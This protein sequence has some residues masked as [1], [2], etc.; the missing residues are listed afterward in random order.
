M[1]RCYLYWFMASGERL[2]KI[3][4]CGFR[5]SR[6][7]YYA[8]LP[9][10]EIQHT[11]Y[12]PPLLATLEKWRN[13]AP[14]GF[15]FTLKAWQ[16]IT[17]QPSSPTYRR[18]KRELSD[19]ERRQA[20]SFRPSGIVEE[21]WETTYEC[22]KALDAKAVLFQC[23]ASFGPT[24]DNLKNMLGFFGRAKRE[25]LKF[26]WEP[27]GGWPPDLIGD[28]CRDLDLWHVVDPFSLRTVTPGRCYFRLHGRGGWRYSYEDEEM[29]E[30]Y[31]MLP[32]G[33]ESYV[34]FNNI[35]MRR[36]AL[37]FKEIASREK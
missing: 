23:P 35:E 13:E 2:V 7:S 25:G 6:E 15:E 10:V 21:A 18:L 14:A 33:A 11:F 36:D 4:C 32:E 17:H 20:G 22:A 1:R 30:L 37:R 26:C 28:L 16:L 24:N 29:E 34:F 12:Q 5:S 8:S 19:G 27:R 3:G 31:S 9:A